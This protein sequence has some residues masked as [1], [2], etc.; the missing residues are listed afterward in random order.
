MLSQS[1]QLNGPPA[2]HSHP[3][4]PEFGSISVDDARIVPTEKDILI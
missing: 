4:L 2:H 3:L 1:I